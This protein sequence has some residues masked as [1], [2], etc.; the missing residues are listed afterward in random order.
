[1]LIVYE[2]L[3]P[4]L[5]GL[6]VSFYLR[7]ALHNL[8]LD[9]CGTA[10]RSDFWVRMTTVLVTAFPLLLAL[11][12]GRSGSADASP[13]SVLRSALLLTTAGIVAGVAIV[14]RSIAKSIPK[15]AK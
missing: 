1:M 5:S 15:V 7:R 8:L 13:E 6:A 4:L 10:V 3:V 11:G 14:G 2:I 12:L 9:I